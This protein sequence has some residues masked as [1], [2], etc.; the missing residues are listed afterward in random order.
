MFT[1]NLI[2]DSSSLNKMESIWSY[3]S[4]IETNLEEGSFVDM[5]R[6]NSEE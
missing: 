4:T 3:L 1:L 2:E 6:L 5:D